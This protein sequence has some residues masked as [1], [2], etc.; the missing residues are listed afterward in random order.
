[1]KSENPLISIVTITYNSEKTLSQ[2]IKSVLNQTYSNIQYIIKD[3]QSTDKTL[4]I[5]RSYNEAFQRKGIEYCILSEKDDGIYE[6]MNYGIAHAKGEIVGLINSDDWYEINAI[7]R[8]VDTYLETHFD[9]FYADLRILKK[10][11]TI[12]K[13]SKFR[14]Y[15]TSR[16][17]N[18]PTTFI[19]NEIYEK[20]H[21]R[22]ECIYDDFDLILRLRKAGYCF[23]VLNE[24][25][26]NFRF[27]GVSN[28]KQLSKAIGRMKLRYQYYRRNGYSRFYILECVVMEMT[29]YL[30][31]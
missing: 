27:G 1:M 20:Y 14:R 16:D 2:T 9:V 30:F 22:T 25:L 29:K 26:A 31:A 8:V 12:I 4:E 10:E 5:A 13:T 24:V 15:V 7:E 21:Y 28:E 3:G 11:K 18:H 6:A 19:R 17:W 23:V